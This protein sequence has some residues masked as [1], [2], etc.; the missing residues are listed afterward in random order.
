[1]SDKPLIPELVE[2]ELPVKSIAEYLTP[3]LREVFDELPMRLREM[4]LADLEILVEPSVLMK[5]LKVG[6]WRE[7][8]K[9]IVEGRTELSLIHAYE[10]ICSR[11]H[12]YEHMVNNFE[13][14]TWLLHP[15]VEY[16]VKVEEA[17]DYGIDKVRKMLEAP[18]YTEKAR[19]AHF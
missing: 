1:M 16:E 10:N 3:K 17:L 2:D 5:R 15:P 7:Y 11:Q 18:L 14:F 6:F 9:T 8:R 19:R 13:H 4:P 12:F